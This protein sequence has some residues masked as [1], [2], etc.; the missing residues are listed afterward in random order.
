M[1]PQPA[2]DRAW[3]GQMSTLLCEEN[4]SSHSTSTLEPLPPRINA[5]AGTA[6]VLMG[7][8]NVKGLFGAE[9]ETRI[10]QPPE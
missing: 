10:A 8:V 1:L 7:H 6:F 4:A 3:G 5:H 9:E 2:D